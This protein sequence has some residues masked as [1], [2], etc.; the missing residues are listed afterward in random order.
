[1]KR[2]GLALDIVGLVDAYQLSG[3]EEA[4]KLLPVVIEKC[5]PHISPV[6]RDRIGKKDPP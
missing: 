3:V 2:Y 4:K 1:M 5:R 6:S